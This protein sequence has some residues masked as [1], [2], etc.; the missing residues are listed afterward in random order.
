MPSARETAILALEAAARRTGA[1]VW[2]GSD[3]ERAIPAEGLIQIA[4]GEYVAEAILSPLAWS[5]E[6]PAEVTVMVTSADETLRD[7]ALDSLLL[8]LSGVLQADLTLGGAVEYTDIG[9]P[10]FLA[11]EADGAAKAA[12]LSVTLCFLSAGSPLT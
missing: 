9:T 6:M 11:F 12:Q 5:H 3:L 10:Q 2:R 7:A 1:E 4:E 8:S